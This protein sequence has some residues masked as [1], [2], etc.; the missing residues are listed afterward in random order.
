VDF[1]IVIEAGWVVSD[2]FG[3]GLLASP[4]T[5][6]LLQRRLR[7]SRN[8]DYG[9]P[10]PPPPNFVTVWVW[11]EIRP[12]LSPVRH[13]ERTVFPRAG[14]CV[15]RAKTFR[16]GSVRSQLNTRYEDRAYE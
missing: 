16:Q 7:F 3:I 13:D 6:D 9:P 10:P 14:H 5:Y 15:Q 12:V 8:T 11:P 4:C 1:C 2:S